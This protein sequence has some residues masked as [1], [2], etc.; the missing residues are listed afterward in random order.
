MRHPQDHLEPPTAASHQG[1]VIAITALVMKLE[2]ATVATNDTG[3]HD[4]SP[5]CHLCSTSQLLIPAYLVTVGVND[6]ALQVKGGEDTNHSHNAFLNTSVPF[7]LYLLRRS[8]RYPVI[9]SVLIQTVIGSISVSVRA[10]DCNR[11]RLISS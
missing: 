2:N 11:G 5:Y 7:S 3:A 8:Y 10:W 9:C 4:M 6:R 1:V